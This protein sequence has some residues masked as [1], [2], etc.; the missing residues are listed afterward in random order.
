MPFLLSLPDRFGGAK[1]LGVKEEAGATIGALATL[2][3]RD[4][5]SGEGG[6]GP[7]AETGRRQRRSRRRKGVAELGRRQQ[8]NEE[9]GSSGFEEIRGPQRSRRWSGG[10]VEQGGSSGAGDGVAAEF[11]RGQQQSW[12]G[13]GGFG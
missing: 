11:G 3:F 9:G 7:A 2:A 12:I 5:C 8:R 10:R 13:G 6:K 4:G 1:Y